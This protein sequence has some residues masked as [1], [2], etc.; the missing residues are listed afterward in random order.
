MCKL[1]ETK[2]V[3]EFTNQRK[4][5]KNCF[6]RW[7]EKKFFYTIRKFEMIQKGDLI[8]YE[9]NEL[10]KHL[11][12]LLES[13]APVQ[14]IKMP[15]KK[16]VSKQVSPETSDDIAYMSINFILNRSLK[17]SKLKPVERKII[18]PLYLFTSKEVAL[19]AKLKK[20]KIPK[21]Q[22]NKFI[23]SLEKKHPEVK[24]SIVKSYLEL[25]YNKR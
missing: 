2:P 5:C 22:I 17:K 16:K 20:L 13:R 11:L 7:F 19:Y 4:V 18:R 9:N 12:K 21:Q 10:I 3:Y 25:F 24:H 15:S 6:I 23:D 8:G 14:I 1:C